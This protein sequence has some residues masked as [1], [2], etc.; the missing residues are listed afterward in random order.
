MHFKGWVKSSLVD[1]PGKIAASLFCGGCNFRCPNCH[2]SGIV[3][4]PN[5][6]PDIPEQELWEFLASRVGWLDGIV[7]SGGEPTLQED[8]IPFALRL[9]EMGYSVK[10][11]TNGYRP[12]VLQE[13]ID[14]RAVD[15]VAM[16]VK[17]SLDPGGYALAAG[18]HVDIDRVRASMDLL[19][20]GSVACEFRTTVVPGIVDED[21]VIRIAQS[22]AVQPGDPSGQRTDNT[23]RVHN[24]RRTNVVRQYYLQQFVARD[25]LDPSLLARVPY[26]AKRLKTMADLARQWVDNVDV[27]GL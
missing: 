22:I 11:D 26:P 15:Y 14:S 1:Y 13:M 18:V 23:R 10:L 20:D 12:D 7:L 24:T 27:R 16:D 21:C 9:H 5:D 19:L 3:L 4:Y 25:T 2:N 17:A 8:L 6:H